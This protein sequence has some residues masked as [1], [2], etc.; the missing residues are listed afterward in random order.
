MGGSTTNQKKQPTPT[1]NKLVGSFENPPEL[2]EKTRSDPPSLTKYLEFPEYL[3]Y[4][5]SYQGYHLY[6]WAI[7][8]QILG[9]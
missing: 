2:G 7:C 3:G 9:L 1:S 4:V 8:P 6:R 5:D